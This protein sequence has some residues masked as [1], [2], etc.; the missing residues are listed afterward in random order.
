MNLEQIDTSTTAGELLPCPFCGSHD[1]G[2]RHV[3]TYS[4]DSSY[5]VFGCKDCGVGFVDGNAEEW[6]IRAD[7]AG[8]RG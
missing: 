1:I 3:V 8:E 2:N 4:V 5:D 7:L 6:N